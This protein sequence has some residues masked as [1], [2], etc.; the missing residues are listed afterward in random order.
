[1]SE[2]DVLTSGVRVQVVSQYVAEHSRPEQAHFFFSYRVRISNEAEAPVRLISRHWIIEDAAGHVEEVRGPGVVGAQPR[3]EQGQ[4]FEYTSF[5]PLPTPKGSM[6][7]TFQMVA[8][9]GEGFD[10]EVGRFEL[11]EPMA[12]N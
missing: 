7:G 5:C 6:R 1:V 9:N 3:L 11:S 12:Y 8:D 10:V 2:S 4:T